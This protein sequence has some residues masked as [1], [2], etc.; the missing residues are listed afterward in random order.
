MGEQACAFTWLPLQCYG[1]EE[2]ATRT[3]KATPHSPLDPLTREERSERMGRVRA[4]DTGPEMAVRRLVFSMGYRYRLHSKRLPGR[5]DLVFPKF[6]KVIF[7]HGCFWHRHEGCA[8]TRVPKTR[9]DFWF[10]K[11]KENRARDRKHQAALVALGWEYAVIWECEAARPDV[12]EKRVR[13]FL[14]GRE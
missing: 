3:A 8:R 1:S 5:P 12:V 10:R 7:V 6:H 2:V 14:E 13:R 9:R 4:K 11:F